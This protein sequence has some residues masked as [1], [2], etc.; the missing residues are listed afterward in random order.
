MA[1]IP[2]ISPIGGRH[3]PQWRHLRRRWPRRPF[4]RA[5]REVHE[6]RK[7][8]Q[9]WGKQGTG[10]GEFDAPHALA[11]DSKGR[12]F[13]GDRGNNR[14]QI[15]DQ[16]GAFLDQWAQFSRPS[17]IFIDKNDMIYVS[18]S[19][20]PEKPATATIPDGREASASAAPRMERSPHLFRTPTLTPMPPLP[21]ARK[22]WWRTL[23]ARSTALKWA[24]R[25]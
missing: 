10:P 15:F 14:I 8:H 18:D 23:R 6:R 16:D 17:G 1:P 2:S 22:A 13:V 3:R 5:H 4:Q 9:D 21:A 24:K 25:T 20:S 19:E 12:L 7:I 11:F